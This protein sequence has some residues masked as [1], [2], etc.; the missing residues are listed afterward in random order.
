LENE[1]SEV[2]KPKHFMRKSSVLFL[3]VSLFAS[4]GICLFHH[5]SGQ[6]CCFARNTDLLSQFSIEEK[7]EGYDAYGDCDSST[8]PSLQEF[9]LYNV[10]L[11]VH[12]Y[13]SVSL[14][15]IEFLLSTPRPPPVSSI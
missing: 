3:L 10:E 2:V 6:Y 14:K 12:P 1:S 9:R 15:Q 5:N 8:G 11:Y 13:Y 4:A 7:Y